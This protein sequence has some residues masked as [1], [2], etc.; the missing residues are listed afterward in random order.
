MHNVI[1]KPGE[2]LTL[3]KLLQETIGYSHQIENL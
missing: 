1:N 2:N 3:Q